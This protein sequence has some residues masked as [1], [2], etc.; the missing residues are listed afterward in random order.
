MEDGLGVDRNTVSEEFSGDHRPGRRNK[1]VSGAEGY[2]KATTTTTR[3]KRIER[4]GARAC[5][6]H[7][8]CFA[9]FA[10]SNGAR[11]PSALWLLTWSFVD[12]WRASLKPISRTCPRIVAT[13][14]LPHQMLVHR[15]KKHCIV[16][17]F[18][19]QWRAKVFV[20]SLV[21]FLAYRC[22]I[23]KEKAGFGSR[24][25]CTVALE[26]KN[27]SDVVAGRR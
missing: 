7:P 8:R 20:D 16:S 27:Q 3:N 12:E 22:Q 5:A 9:V 15:L 2:S 19:L 25:V 6:L 17:G 14:D 13:H 26:T 18:R 24:L 10:V 4:S 11:G 1:G 23:K 21:K